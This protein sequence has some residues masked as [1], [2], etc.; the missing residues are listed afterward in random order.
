MHIEQ[1]RI[2][3]VVSSSKQRKKMRM[4]WRCL[5]W[6]HRTIHPSIG[7]LEEED[8]DGVGEPANGQRWPTLV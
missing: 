4:R 6:K 3:R 8:S 7:K 5:A 1:D 2:N